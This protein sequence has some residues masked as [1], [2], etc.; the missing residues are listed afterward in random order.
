MICV[1]IGIEEIDGYPSDHH[2]PGANMNRTTEGLHRG[3]P[4][5]SARSEHRHER[6]GA[7]VVLLVAVFLPAIGSQSLVEVALLIEQT[8]AHHGDAQIA[9]RLAMIAGEHAEAARV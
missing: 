7:D 3:E 2:L 5:L 4:G 9:G 6:S 8:H 1:Q